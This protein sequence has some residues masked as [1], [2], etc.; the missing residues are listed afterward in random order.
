ME[1]LQSQGRLDNNKMVKKDIIGFVCNDLFPKLKF[2]M[3]KQ[4]LEY[5]LFE[6]SICG[7]ICPALG[8][9]TA[10][11]AVTCWERH[12]NMF[13]DVLHAKRE[14]MSLVLSKRNF[15]ISKKPNLLQTLIV[16]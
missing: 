12:K 7:K 3:G 13:A 15:C 11:T 4:Q 10:A 5:S 1:A 6:N 2:I 14:R 9:K 8:M 16:Y